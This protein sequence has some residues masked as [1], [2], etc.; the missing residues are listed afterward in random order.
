MSKSLDVGVGQPG[1]IH[2]ASSCS[3]LLN[4]LTFLELLF[5]EP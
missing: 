1:L 2:D 3:D 4:S 5:I